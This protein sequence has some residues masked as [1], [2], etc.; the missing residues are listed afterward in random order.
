ML[1]CF[2]ENYIVAAC[3]VFYKKYHQR[4]VCSEFKKMKYC[5]LL[6][7]AY[8]HIMDERNNLLDTIKDMVI[9]YQHFVFCQIVYL[10]HVYPKYIISLV[11]FFRQVLYML[12]NTVQSFAI[13]YFTI[14]SLLLLISCCLLIDYLLYSAYDLHMKN[15]NKTYKLLVHVVVNKQPPS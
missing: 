6:K 9:V 14:W 15:I 4:K 7:T 8:V 3:A 13:N 10:L 5:E 12:L 2:R 11:Y 1:Q